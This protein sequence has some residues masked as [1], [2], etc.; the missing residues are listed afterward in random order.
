MQAFPV[1][2]RSRGIVAHT[3]AG[4]LGIALVFATYALAERAAV[5]AA[6]MP[7]GEEQV[8]ATAEMPVASDQATG[9]GAGVTTGVAQGAAELPMPDQAG[10]RVG[11]AAEPEP[12]LTP[13]QPTIA[14]AFI[15]QDVYSSEDPESDKIGEVNDLI[16]GSDGKIT[17]AVIGVGGFLGI[18]EKDV[19]VPFEELAVVE[20][21]GDIRLVYA[22]T[23]EQLEAAEAFDR[24]AYDPRARFQEEQAAQAEAA[25]PA[26]DTGLTPAPATDMAA[27]PV[28]QQAAATTEQPADQQ[29]A[30]TAE[31]P[32]DQQ[33]AAT[34]EQPVD[35]QAAATTEQPADQQAAATAEQPADQQAAATTEQPA[36]G[37]QQVA[38]SQGG[39]DLFMSFNAEQ[40]RASK[41]MGQEIY[42]AD[43]ESIGE[44]ADLVLQEDGKTRAATVDVGG[45]LGVGEKRVAI[46][47][48]EIEVAQNPD[49]PDEPRLQVALSKQQLEEAPAWEDQTMA[50]ADANADQQAAATTEQPAGQQMAA[51]EPDDRAVSG[52]EAGPAD[53]AYEALVEEWR[54]RGIT[55]P[56]N[57]PALRADLSSTGYY[58]V[59]VFFGTNRIND[60]DFESPSFGDR[61]GTQLSLGS[62]IVTIP[63]KHVT[64]QV[65]RPTKWTIWRRDD[66]SEIFLL[67]RTYILTEEDFRKEAT[68]LLSRIDSGER[69]ALVFIHGYNVKFAD[70]AFRVAQIVHDIQ[71]NGAPFFF[72]WPSR[73]NLAD[74]EY[75]QQSARHAVAYLESFLRLVMSMEDIDSVSII[76]HSLGNDPLLEAIRNLSRDNTISGVEK[77]KEIILV[78]PDIDKDLYLELAKHLPALSRNITLY[79]S[80][81]DRAMDAARSYARGV[82]RAGDVPPVVIRSVEA[83]DA[84][85]LNTGFFS[86]NHSEYAENRT[87]LEDIDRLLTQ[88]LHPP[89]QRNATL[90]KM[91][92]RVGEEDL[93]YWVYPP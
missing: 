65:E 28:D 41:I 82:P 55:P 77:V 79:A 45:F 11:L 16:I 26:A 62:L 43:N 10:R 72:S 23:K 13:V 8:A 27:Q 24:T 46:P 67:N 44:V 40:V 69:T 61:R 5:G 76:A 60:G 29:A 30:A 3:A 57:Y 14:T 35:Q 51:T 88:G 66:P 4:L 21:E 50:S 58:S 7:V 36:T 6:E 68:N 91:P 33:A 31:Q 64:G 83:I 9:A 87:L 18:G 53:P 34:T 93:F 25:A 37:E 56:S 70:V 38:T 48:N 63:V 84:T 71:F 54:A 42:G 47:F 1:W 2:L 92:V 32:A 39:E 49:N 74:Y 12:T 59:Q 78:A 89:D 86:L 85:A 15:G 90:R 73:G 80:G 81:K 22:A 52:D 19:A 20:R 17:H 75:D